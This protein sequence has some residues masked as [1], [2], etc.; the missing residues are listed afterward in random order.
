MPSRTP[1]SNTP[2]TILIAI[3][4]IPTVGTGEPEKE[5]QKG[6]EANPS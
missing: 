1:K 3:V 4:C 2:P 5:F 6:S